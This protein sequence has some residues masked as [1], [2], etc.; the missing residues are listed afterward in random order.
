MPAAIDEPLVTTSAFLPTVLA[1]PCK[2]HGAKPG[3]PCWVVPA[4]ESA[5]D[6]RAVCGRRAR[7]RGFWR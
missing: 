4:D 2:A 7:A 1:L 3:H 5:N 6:H